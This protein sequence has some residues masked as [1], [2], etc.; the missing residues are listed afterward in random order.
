MT[1]ENTGD[2]FHIFLICENSKTKVFGKV[3]LWLYKLQQNK[4]FTLFL[5]FDFKKKGRLPVFIKKKYLLCYDR[6]II[7]PPW[8]FALHMYLYV[9]L[10]ISVSF[11]LCNTDWPPCYTFMYT[12][13]WTVADHRGGAG[14]VQGVG[15]PYFITVVST[16][17]DY[18]CNRTDPSGGCLQFFLF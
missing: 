7:L 16:V 12:Y 5:Q 15:T 8:H 1:G 6:F 17:Q 11:S 10:L 14:E 9:L 3:L 4:L 18:V 13:V 2:K